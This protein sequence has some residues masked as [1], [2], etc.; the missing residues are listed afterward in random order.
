MVRMILMGMWMVSTAKAQW[1]HS[2]MLAG[3]AG[4]SGYKDIF[5]GISAYPAA[6]QKGTLGIGFFGE[7]RY[8]TDLSYYDLAF[9]GDISGQPFQVRLIREGNTNF[10]STTASLAINKKLSDQI[11]IALKPGYTFSVAKGY[12]SMGQPL[13]GIGVLF[14]LNSKLSWGLQADGINSFF[15]NT[16]GRYFVV[17]TG[18]GYM[19]SDLAFLSFEAVKEQGYPVYSMAGIHYVFMEQME[20]KFG[21]AFQL[22]TAS[23]GLGYRYSGLHLAISASYHL[24]LGASAGISVNWQF[25]SSE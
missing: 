13:A 10:S 7:K 15:M 1:G 23:L 19:V 20:A 16:E 22:S 3:A 11:T 24:S 5:W 12:G 18:I 9:A 2:N 17:R 6:M 14:R 25:K 8:M 21:Y 4:L